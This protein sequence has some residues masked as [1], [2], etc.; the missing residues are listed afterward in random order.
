MTTQTRATGAHGLDSRQG[1]RQQP[2][3][4]FRRGSTPAHGPHRHEQFALPWRERWLGFAIAVTI[5][6][7]W[8]VVAG[9]WTPRGPLTSG[10]ALAAMGISLLVGGA[11][12]LAMRSRWA[13]L[14]APVAFAVV[15]EVVRMGTDGPTVDAIHLSEYGIIAFAVGRGFHALVA[16]VPMM[17]G[18]A[19]GAAIARR[20]IRTRLGDHHHT[21]GWTGYLGLATTTVVAIG[22]ASLAVAL[23]RPAR[24]DPILGDDGTPLA[25]S[26]AE[27]ATVD[28]NG[29]DLGMMIRGTS[30]DDPVLLFLAGG[31][32]GTELGAMRT[33]LQSL[34]DHFVVVTWDQ[35]GTGRSYRALDPTSTVTFDG[36][37]DDTVA[38]VEYL[39]ERFDEDKVFLLGQS[40]GTFLGVATVQARPDLFHAYVGT[41]QMVNATAT[42]RIFY[43]DALAWARETG[44]DG[45][46][47]TLVENGPPPYDQVLE[48]EPALKWEH[49]VYPYD[50][51]GNSEGAGGFSEN[52][53]VEEYALIDQVHAFAGF[54]DTFAVLYP[55]LQMIDFRTQAA[56][57]D[58]PV[59]LVQGAHEAPGRAILADEWYELLEAPSKDMVRLDTS[60]HR[61]LF[62]QPDEFTTYMVRSVLGDAAS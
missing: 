34:E 28:V 59:H 52:I 37:V 14:A 50:H 5:A 49:E 26:I 17:L 24:T 6:G 19:I 47:A 62:E 15:F 61:P 42:D 56:R 3:Q 13:L 23:V 39:R 41:G 43:E 7:T 27:L 45:L 58:V 57:L 46:V 12:G 1:A 51:T 38:V 30:T 4:G 54:L 22:L 35:R 44:N 2:R 16:L 29:H 10:E 9:V 40:Y 33:H 18:A 21:R 53:I 20:L 48:N 55:Q 25:G 11:A 60:G 8:G 32:G 36:A 31:P